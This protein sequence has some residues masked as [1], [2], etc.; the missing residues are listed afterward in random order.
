MSFARNA[1]RFD[2]QKCTDRPPDGTRGGMQLVAST[3]RA[4][5]YARVFGVGR[6]G[7][8]LAVAQYVCVCVCVCYVCMRVCARLYVVYL[9]LCYLIFISALS[10]FVT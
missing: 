5:K 7:V 8:I 6:S 3:E 10:S 9:M 4:Q 1:N 2:A